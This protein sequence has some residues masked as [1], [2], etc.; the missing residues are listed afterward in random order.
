[1]NWAFHVFLIALL[2][3]GCASRAITPQ[4][5]EYFTGGKQF[6][7]VWLEFYR[8]ALEHE[9][10]LDDP[11]IE[12]GA[13]MVPA[14]CEAITH[15]DMKYRGYAIGALGFIGDQRAVASLV[16]IL[17]DSS[18][19]GYFRGDAL[20]A[21]YV[22]DAAEGIR[23]AREYTGSDEYVSSIAAAVLRGASWLT[24]PSIEE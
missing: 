1:L 16:S 18:E 23:L 22:I 24:E 14:I 4:P 3:S 8:P 5:G 19:I 2:C 20:Q 12:A 6:E 13:A 11:L 10:E 15:E 17:K 7:P 21:I 9:P